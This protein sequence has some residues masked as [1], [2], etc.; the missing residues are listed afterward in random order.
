MTS[1]S[2]A[3]IG[4]RH[5]SLFRPTFTLVFML[6][7]WGAASAPSLLGAEDTT[8]E[9]KQRKHI[10]GALRKG[11]GNWYAIQLMRTSY[12]DGGVRS[13]TI[14]R[15][16]RGRLVVRKQDEVTENRVLVPTAKYEVVEGLEPAVDLIIKHVGPPIVKATKTHR[17]ADQEPAA[18]VS[19]NF[20]GR[21]KTRDEA[22]AQIDLARQTFNA[23]P[24]WR[25]PEEKRGRRAR[26]QQ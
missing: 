17:A 19:W 8:P 5:L 21:Y 14:T 23:E 24:H 16:V 11:H 13:V 10:T 3:D 7:I 12:S 20:L 22:D 2:P 6:T 1:R 4:S 26:L 18:E 15:M 25:A 9:A